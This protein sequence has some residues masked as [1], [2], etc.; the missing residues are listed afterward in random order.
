MNLGSY[1]VGP[2]FILLILPAP[3]YLPSMLCRWCM[4][5]EHA[6][7]QGRS[8]QQSVLALREERWQN[9]H[10]RVAHTWTNGAQLYISHASSLVPTPWASLAPRSSWL[11]HLGPLP[12][13]LAGG[14]MRLRLVRPRGL[15][16]CV[17]FSMSWSKAMCCVLTPKPIAAARRHRT[18]SV[19]P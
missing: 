11:L 4:V 12:W 13:R 18:C 9:H 7:A 17:P 8:W 14:S 10:G 3:P 19:W 2:R 1:Q 6:A 5:R 15:L 16:T